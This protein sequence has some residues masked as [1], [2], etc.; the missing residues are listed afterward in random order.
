MFTLGWFK[1]YV[2]QWNIFVVQLATLLTPY[3]TV[4]QGQMVICFWRMSKIKGGNF[5]TALYQE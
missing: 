3:H 4:A 1:N 2:Q 5:I